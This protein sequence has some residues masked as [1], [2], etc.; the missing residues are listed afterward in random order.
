MTCPKCEAKKTQVIDT[1]QLT[2]DT[3]VRRRKC[4]KCGHCFRTYETR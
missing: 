3:T 1:R 4:V 2:N